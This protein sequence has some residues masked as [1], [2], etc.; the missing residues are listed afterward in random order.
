HVQTF[1]KTRI[2]PLIRACR[3]RAGRRKVVLKETPT[4]YERHKFLA[5]CLKAVIMM[6]FDL[7]QNIKGTQ[8]S[9]DN[10]EVLGNMA[11]A[12]DEDYIQ[13][14]DS[15]IPEKLKNCNDFSDQQITAMETVICSGNTTYGYSVF[16]LIC[17]ETQAHG[18]KKLEQ[19]DILPLYLTENFWK[20]ISTQCRCRSMVA[21]KNSLEYNRCRPYREMLTYLVNAC[22][23]SLGNITQVTISNNAFPFGYDTTMFNHCLSAQVVMDNLASLT[24]KVDDDDTQKLI[25]EKRT[26]KGLSDQQVQQINKW[27]I[28]TVDT[29]AALMD[30]GNGEWDS[31]KAKVIVT[32]FL[33]AGN[34]LGASEFN[35]IGGP[36]LCALD[37]SVL[38]GIRNDN[39]DALEITSCSSA[40]KKAFFAVAE[41]AFPINFIQTCATADQLTSYQTY[42]GKVSLFC[43]HT[44]RRWF[45]S[46]ISCNKCDLNDLVHSGCDIREHL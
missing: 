23:D 5:E 3:R 24:E 26:P 31:N 22:P 38:Q 16:I 1:T 30:N 12:L 15:Y 29:L 20:H 13:S 7:F 9:R 34:S 33:S 2:K 11:C 18:L 28:T 17:S 46:W 44:E 27:N 36:N 35:S 10:V 41:I 14:A 45:V 19:L 40:H 42:L 4:D 37:L 21:R 39:A 32:K 6:T 43:I 8:L 25:L